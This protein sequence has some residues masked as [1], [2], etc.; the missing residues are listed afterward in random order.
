MDLR[1]RLALFQAVY[2]VVTG[3]WPL[4]SMSTFEK[5][6]GPKVDRWLVKMVG[7]LV[8]I[9]GGVVGLAGLRRRLSV[10]VHLLAIFSAAG[11]AAIDIVYS[12]RGRISPIYLLDALLEFGIIGGWLLSAKRNL[13]ERELPPYGKRLNGLPMDY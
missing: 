11:F 12:L 3:L 1:T 7:I 8:T 10:E 6:T 4:F 5:V 9:I 2:Y 13:R